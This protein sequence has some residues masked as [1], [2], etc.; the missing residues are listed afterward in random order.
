ML[1]SD[2]VM[3]LDDDEN[4]DDEMMKNLMNVSRKQSFRLVM[5][6][7]LNEMILIL[8]DENVNDS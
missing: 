4:F 8:N 2:V 5:A 1:L 7:H 3:D 6:A